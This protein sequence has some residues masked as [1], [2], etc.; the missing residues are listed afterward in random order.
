VSEADVICALGGDGFMLQTLHQH[1]G[2]RPA[3]LRQKLGTVA[4]S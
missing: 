2:A 4:S 3:V 1:G